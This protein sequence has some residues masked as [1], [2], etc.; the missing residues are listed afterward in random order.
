MEASVKPTANA[1]L[2][3]ADIS[4]WTKFVRRHV[5]SASHAREIIVQLLRAIIAASEPPLTVAELE[6]D[7]VFLYA[8]GEEDDLEDVAAKV[9]AQIPRLFRAFATEMKL[10]STRPRCSCEA[11]ASVER[12]RLKQVVHAGEVALE[13]IGKFE[14][15]FGM[16]VIVV[17]RMLKNSVQEKE[18]LMISE[19]AYEA[20]GGF[21]DLKPEKRSEK[22]SGVG[23]LETRVYH[24]DQIAEVLRCLEL[25]EGS[26]PEPS[27]GRII[28]W[29]LKLMGRSL[30]AMATGT[31]FRTSRDGSL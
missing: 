1:I 5:V 14:K 28:K 9:K 30:V 21:Y 23:R 7:A 24:E 13:Q 6:G 10:L 4:G 18:Y 2:L 29:R 11:C 31:V 27:L 3:V 17:H 8:L 22:L 20:L 16:A 19:P 15:L 25:E 12:L 26:L